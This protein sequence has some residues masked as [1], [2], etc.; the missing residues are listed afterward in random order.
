LFRTEPGF[1]VQDPL[2]V[3]IVARDTVLHEVVDEVAPADVAT[4]AGLV[5]AN[6]LRLAAK[7][8]IDV[9]VALLTLLLAMP[10]MLV[11]AIA[12]VIET[13]G[14]ALYV[15]ERVG[16]NGRRFRMLKFRSMWADAHAER[17][18]ILLLNELSGPVFKLR[19]DPRVTRVGRFLRR[20][21]LDELPQ[22]VNVLKGDMSLVG[23][24]PALPEEVATYGD[25]ERRR[26]QVRPGLTC[27]WQVSGRSEV[28]FGTWI[29]MDLEYID[30]WTLRMDIGLLLRTVPA[31][32]SCRG[33]Y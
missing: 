19:E 16:K 18:D 8:A 6:R 7:R 21:S 5:A 23:P 10:F 32:V 31:V 22:L 27:I 2:D 20:A 30:R 1:E 29:D 13:P 12:I 25:R 4:S 11:I 24:R 26:L 28:D 14:P 15:Q 3:R 17:D 9:V 33:A